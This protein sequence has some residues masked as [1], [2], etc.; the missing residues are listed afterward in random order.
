MVAYVY[1]LDARFESRIKSIRIF[2][3]LY[4][5]SLSLSFYSN[6]EVSS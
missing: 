3:L 5:V 6:A 1:L 2:A 4:S